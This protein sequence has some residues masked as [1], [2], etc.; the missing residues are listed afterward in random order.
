MPRAPRIDI[1][2][3][4]YHVTN[5]GV[6]RLPLFHD[7]EDRL[8][9]LDWMQETRRRYAIEIEQFSLMTNHYHLLIRLL[10]GSLSLA[11]KYFMS[12][13]ARWFNKKNGHTGHLFQDRFHSLP[14][15]EDAYYTTVCRYIHLNA[16]KARIVQK[17]EDHRWSNYADLVEGRPNP[18]ATGGMILDYFGRDPIT[19]RTRYQLFVEEGIQKPEL[20]DMKTLLRMRSWGVLPKP[21]ISVAP[22]Q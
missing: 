14:V 8:E 22:A 16:V 2:E 5:R 19:Q 10:D 6:K 4:V 13:Y 7:D 18:H 11:M 3:L 15:Q 12:R 17:P 9:F 1:P 20:I 21:L